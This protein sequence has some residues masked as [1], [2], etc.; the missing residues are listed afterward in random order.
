[1]NKRRASGS[2]SE[3]AEPPTKNAKS[4]VPKG[5]TPIQSS[6]VG[7]YPIG[8][9]PIP[10]ASLRPPSPY[11]WVPIL[12]AYSPA[13]APEDVSEPANPDRSPH[14]SGRS[15]PKTGLELKQEFGVFIQARINDGKM[16]PHKLK[17]ADEIRTLY[18]LLAMVLEPESRVWAKTTEDQLLAMPT[19][20]ALHAEFQRMLH[21]MF[22]HVDKIIDVWG[23]TDA[24]KV[25]GKGKE[26]G[27]EDANPKGEGSGRDLEDRAAQQRVPTWYNRRCVLSNVGVVDAAHIIDVKASSS[28]G[29]PTG[30]WDTLKMFWP[31]SGEL[32]LEIKGFENQNILPLEPTAHRLW[33]RQ[34][35]GLRPVPHPSDIRSLYL[36][37]VWF[38]ER[39]AESGFQERGEDSDYPQLTD[40]R[41]TVA[42]GGLSG[43]QFIRHG[44]VY[45]I[46][47]TD[48]FNFKLPS[49]QFLAVRYAVQHLLAGMKAAGALSDV[50][51]DGP[52]SDD[53]AAPVPSES[54]MPSDWDVMLKEA[55]ELG[56]L[57]EDT[58]P[59]WRRC[60]LREQYRKVLVWAAV[61]GGDPESELEYISEEDELP[62]DE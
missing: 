11:G 16:I 14:A 10:T 9:V 51:G 5:S 35:F 61:Y 27:K 38:S 7:N 31:L 59:I 37:V 24:M 12:R 1:M 54:L 60:I 25:D 20:R 58:E 62:T 34:H 48:P 15:F 39:H 32:Y 42:H 52:P 45:E 44:D 17:R 47:T 3:S 55:L 22:P 36:Q 29:L 56:I 41:R 2:K 13:P 4:C 18:A 40:L 21:F 50:F 49:L 8:W 33:D 46:R 53:P 28:M 6:F 26:K 19:I 57:T 23:G 43:A 30:F